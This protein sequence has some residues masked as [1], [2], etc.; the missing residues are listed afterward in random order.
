[1]PMPTPLERLLRPSTLAIVGASPETLAI[2]NNVL[3]NVERSGFDGPLH[4]VSRNRDTINV[5][6]LNLL[7]W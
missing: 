3:V 7:K 2:G 5:D 1:M 6:R 4:L